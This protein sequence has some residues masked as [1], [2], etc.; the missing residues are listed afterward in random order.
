MNDPESRLA[1]L[2]ED[3]RHYT[4]LAELGV[5]PV[6]GYLSKVRNRTE[7]SGSDEHV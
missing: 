7:R 3:S 6:V 1:K 2:K 4:V 5:K